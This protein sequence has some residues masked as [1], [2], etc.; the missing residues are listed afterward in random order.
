MTKPAKKPARKV[1]VT[2]A[3]SLKGMDRELW[4]LFVQ[5]AQAEGR[6]VRWLLDRFIQ[7]YAKREP[8]NIESAN[9]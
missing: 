7:S 5:R 4:T 1:P 6:T 9:G 3:Y 2:S 8:L